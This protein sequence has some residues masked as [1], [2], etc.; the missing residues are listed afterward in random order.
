MRELLM[1]LLQENTMTPEQLLK[2]K[3]EYLM[4]C[5]YHFYQQPPHI[6]AGDGSYLIDSE[7]KRYLDCFTGVTVMSAGHCN[8]QIIE[9]VIEQIR[10]LGHTT[11]IY[12]TE[13]MLR[14]AQKL[15][16]ITP[17][18]LK[19]SFFC[20]SGSE[21]IEGAMLL[22]ALH[23]GRSEMV[24]FTDGL[25]GRTKAAMSATGLPMW[26]TDPFPL[27]TIHHLPFGDADALETFMKT[28][29]HRIAAVIGEPVQGNGG[30][31]IPP[32][33]FWP[34]VRAITK[35][36]E[37]LLIL[38]EIQTGFNRTGRWFACEHWN[39]VPDVMALSKAMGNGFPIA[40]FITT[41]DI[42]R[43]YTRPGAST[44]GGNPVC[45]TAALATI[46]YHQQ[47]HLDKQAQLIGHELLHALK[48]LADHSQRFANAR[49]LG[50]MLGI[51]VVDSSGL[52]DA[53]ACDQLLEQLK[54]R[55][56]LAGKTGAARNVL[57][58]LPP[59]TL[60]PIELGDLIHVLASFHD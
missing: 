36:H 31:H 23:T 38:D 21:A 15:A 7:G 53:A 43:S 19:R 8:A 9:P 25:H 42:A 54:D 55:G 6:V 51:D 59:L 57:T 44:Y 24:A 26:R 10:T 27:T 17:G 52:P 58:F 49:G 20:A 45:A 32:D 37:S 5:V 11:S 34:R 1:T 47:H 22:A 46:N 50:L 56:V 48:T 40:A 13:P 3:A 39:V 60:S 29:G 12:L 16:Q 2:L 4:P 41:D 28:H 30:I 14:L 33:D 35:A 18:K